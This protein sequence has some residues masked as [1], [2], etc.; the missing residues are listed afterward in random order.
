M[1]EHRK[2]TDAEAEEV[3][4]AGGLFILGTERHESRPHRQPAAGP[5]RPPGRPGESRFYLALT[6]DL[7]RLFGG[8]R[9]AGMM[10][11]L[12]IDEDTP[13]DQKVLS[14]RI[15]QAQKNVESRNFQTRKSVLEYDDVMNV[16][17]TSY[18]P[19]AKKS[20]TARTCAGPSER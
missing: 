20:S 15:E 13:L 18:T 19:S 1:A 6:D 5:R 4:A 2:V 12:K 10:E 8:E 9:I 7:L 16:Q 11:T 14:G 17:R 3:K